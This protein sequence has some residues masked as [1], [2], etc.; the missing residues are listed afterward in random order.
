LRPRAG[1]KVVK[2][3]KPLPT[4][5]R[6][7]HFLIM[8]HALKSSTPIIDPFFELC[9][10]NVTP[11]ER[12]ASGRDIAI[13]LLG[14]CKAFN[15]EGT[16]MIVQNNDFI[17]TQVAALQNFSRIPLNPRSTITNINIRV[18]GRYYGDVAGEMKLHSWYHD[19]AKELKV[20]VSQGD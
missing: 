14:A 10:G 12:K 19:H 3:P 1:G 5:P 17:F 7:V 4:L 20:Q 11:E 15:E 13:G 18:V 9:K 8:G 16:R 2:P 6:E